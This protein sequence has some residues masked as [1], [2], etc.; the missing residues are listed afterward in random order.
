M[1]EIDDKSGCKDHEIC[2]LIY[3]SFVITM[4]EEKDDKLST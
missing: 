2:V 4:D 1:T 3:L